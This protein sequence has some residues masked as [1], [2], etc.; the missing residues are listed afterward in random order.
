M[1]ELP[2]VIV[3][4]EGGF[5][6]LAFPLIHHEIFKDGRNSIEARG[7]H[8]NRVVGFRVLLHPRWDRKS[9]EGG[10]GSIYWGKVSLQSLGPESDDLALSLDELYGT[11]TG[12]RK[13]AEHTECLAVGLGND[14][15]QIHRQII[16]MKLFFDAKDEKPYAE[17]FINF[18]V[19][20]NVV[21]LREK[22]PEYRRGVVLG[23]G[24]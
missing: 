17:V 6:D 10:G 19:S 18:N 16:N 8:N 20:A 11:N 14:P 21:E 1:E 12:V 23:I 22:D 9:L 13:M 2:K 15:R 7:R 24:E 4:M 3:Q 5:I